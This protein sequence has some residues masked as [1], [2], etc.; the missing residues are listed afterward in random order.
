MTSDPLAAFLYVRGLVAEDTPLDD[1]RARS[2][3]LRECITKLLTDLDQLS[4]DNTE[5]EIQ[6]VFY[7]AGKLHFLDQLRWWF[8]VVY[9]MIL[10]Q[11][12]GPRLGQL[13]K[14][15][16]LDWVIHRIQTQTQNA[17]HHE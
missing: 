1:I 12:D 11:E 9:Q 10:H 4:D 16:T 14:I 17:W 2:S 6:S 13:T 5:E 7:E 15:M 8:R 3:L